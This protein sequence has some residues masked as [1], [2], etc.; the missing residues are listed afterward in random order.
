MPGVCP[1]CIRLVQ[2]GETCPVCRGPLIPTAEWEENKEQF[3]PARPA[4]P[5]PGAPA[6]QPSM[7]PVPAAA[8]G[9]PRVRLYGLKVLLGAATSLLAFAGLLAL[10]CSGKGF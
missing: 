10:V 7:T 3:L 4:D 9:E 5:G 8:D 6:P 1:N 2:E